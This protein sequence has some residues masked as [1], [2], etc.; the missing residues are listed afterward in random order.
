MH[1][2]EVMS[3]VKYFWNSNSFIEL[4][5]TEP[6]RSGI[7]FRCIV[8]P[9]KHLTQTSNQTGKQVLKRLMN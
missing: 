1:S 6:K 9:Q 8:F 2:E 4:H 7:G 3:A 5:H